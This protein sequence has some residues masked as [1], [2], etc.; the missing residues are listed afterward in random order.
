MAR[1]READMANFEISDNLGISL[2]H[3]GVVLMDLAPKIYDTTRLLKILDDEEKEHFVP[4]NTPAYAQDGRAVLLND[5]TVGK[6]DLALSIGPSATTRRAE[7]SEALLEMAKNYPP[8]MEVGADII[9]EGMDVPNAE[10][11]AKRIRRTIPEH[12]LGEEH[13]IPPP[14]PDP[15]AE[16]GKMQEVR[17]MKASA[18]KK[19]AEA[20]MRMKQAGLAEAQSMRELRTAMKLDSDASLN[21]AKAQKE[22]AD[23]LSSLVPQADPNEQ[24]R[25]EEV[26]ATEMAERGAKV[27]LQQ[28]KVRRQRVGTVLDV[29]KATKPEPKPKGPTR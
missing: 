8:L 13:D 6:Y 16:E 17:E 12:I 7:G 3:A 27:Q 2:R 26:H 29:H 14:P 4:I 9:V 25:A 10:R 5:L 18:D 21:Q 24:R 20:H 19:E 1:Q 23:A 15:L 28:E 22:Q 11:L